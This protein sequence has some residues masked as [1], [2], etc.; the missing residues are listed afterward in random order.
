[1]AYG[2]KFRL[3]FADDNLKGKKIEILK[4]EGLM[5]QISYLSFQDLL[6]FDKNDS[7]HEVKIN[8]IN[9]ILTISLN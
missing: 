3:E 5:N 2:V 1:M 6:D 4:D 7:L 8:K 9:K